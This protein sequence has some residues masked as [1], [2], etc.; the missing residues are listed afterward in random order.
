M[1]GGEDVVGGRSKSVLF[2][3]RGS[4]GRGVVFRF[5]K[6]NDGHIS[7]VNVQ[8][9]VD[10]RRYDGDFGYII[11]PINFHFR[12]LPRR[13]T[14]MPRLL[15][16]VKD[17]RAG[18]YTHRKASSRERRSKA[19]SLPTSKPPRARSLPHIPFPA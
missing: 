12:Y 10:D 8:D 19:A 1:S 16:E 15:R 14:E 6:S 2:R 5:A 11:V 18:G 3:G 9:N 7:G 4:N 13:R 17:G